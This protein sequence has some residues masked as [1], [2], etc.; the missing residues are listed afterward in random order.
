[1]YNLCVTNSLTV[2]IKELS[3]FILLALFPTAG[4]G[5]MLSWF[6]R[7]GMGWCFAVEIT[8]SKG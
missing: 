5:R 1:M 2:K 6:D 7:G 3:Q 8:V 4:L